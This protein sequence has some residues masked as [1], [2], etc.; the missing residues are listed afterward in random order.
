MKKIFFAVGAVLVLGLSA[1]AAVAAPTFLAPEDGS[2][3]INQP[4]GDDLYAA[5]SNVIINK[6]IQGDLIATGGTIDVDA[7][8]SGDVLVFGGTVIIRGNVGDDVRIAGGQVS[9]YGAVGDDLLIGGGTVSLGSAA[10]IKGDVLV[11][12]GNLTLDG[13]VLGS[14]RV[15]ADTVALK[16]TISGNAEVRAGDSLTMSEKAR[17]G[18]TL[19]YWAET[20]NSDFAKNAGKVEFHKAISKHMSKLGVIGAFAGMALFVT[21]WK[22]LGLLIMGA[23]LIL[24]F[25][26]YMPKVAGDI[27]KNHWTTLGY[28][29][30][31][32]VLVPLAMVVLAVTVV[33]IPLAILLGII[34]ALVL[35]AGTVNGSYYIGQLLVRNDKT[36]WAQLGGMLVG[37]LIFGLLAFIP[38]VGWIAG[39][40]IM[41]LGLGGVI[42]EQWKLVKSYR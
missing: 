22:L 11:G 15:A 37:T 16:G 20:E 17:V 41:L 10:V 13:K 34:Y 3:T 7:N 24:L 27:R 8:V 25:P 5:G 33:G 1:T 12:A 38:V 2:V 14:A 30:L 21:F 32:M 42:A 28:G 4:L 40:W 26:K 29:L 9:I 39:L 35:V 18:G 31:A 23:V 36:A 6:P 19:K